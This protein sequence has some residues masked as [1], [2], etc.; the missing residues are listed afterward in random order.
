MKRRGRI[1][2][3]TV[4]RKGVKLKNKKKNKK[5]KEKKTMKDNT[6]SNII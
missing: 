3:R 4:W 1:Q 6:G 5:Q 2:T